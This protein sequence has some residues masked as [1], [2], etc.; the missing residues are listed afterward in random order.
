MKFI[1]TIHLDSITC[2][3]AL[4][5]SFVLENEVL[6]LIHND[7]GTVDIYADDMDK[8]TFREKHDAV[9]AD[10]V[11]L[12]AALGR[13]GEALQLFCKCAECVDRRHSGSFHEDYLVEL[14]TTAL[15]L[16]CGQ[17][18]MP[19]T[20][21]RDADNIERDTPVLAL[22]CDVD[23]AYDE[24]KSHTAFNYINEITERHAQDKMSYEVAMDYITSMCEG[25]YLKDPEDFID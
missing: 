2:E 12:E 9:H 25:D 19:Y 6:E 17:M 14:A 7:N 18:T 5:T 4:V 3:E 13:G 16:K 24:L 1:D 11:L 22:L 21:R 15:S 20:W 10:P 23:A 8:A